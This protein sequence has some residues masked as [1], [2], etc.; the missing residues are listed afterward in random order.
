MLCHAGISVFRSYAP[1]L[2]EDSALAEQRVVAT[3]PARTGVPDDFA[4]DADRIGAARI[5]SR[6]Q[7][8]RVFDVVAVPRQRSARSAPDSRIAIRIEVQ[9]TGDLAAIIDRDWLRRVCGAAT[10]E[11]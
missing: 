11:D 7:I 10:I 2:P 5:R 1:V 8:E 9:V 3:V 6:Q 4:V